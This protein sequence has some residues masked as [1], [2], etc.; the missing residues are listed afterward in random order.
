MEGM[1]QSPELVAFAKRLDEICDD[2]GVPRLGKGRPKKIAKQLGITD[3]AARRWFGAETY[4]S[5]EHITALCVWANV[6]VDWLMTGRPPKREADRY[7]NPTIAE[8]V[9]TLAVM[10]PAL[11]Y[12]AKIIVATLADDPPPNEAIT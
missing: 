4:P 6:N 7:A 8:I 1:D 11:Q 9:E 2:M 12:K 5:W 3:A 10:E